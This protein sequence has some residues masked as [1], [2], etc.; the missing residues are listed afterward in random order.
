MV[1]NQ[2]WHQNGLCIEKLAM[3]WELWSKTFFLWNPSLF[4]NAAQILSFPRADQTGTEPLA[5]TACSLEWFNISVCLICLSNPWLGPL[6]LQE[7][8]SKLSKIHW[9]QRKVLRLFN[10]LWCCNVYPYVQL[11]ASSPY[12]LT[13]PHHIIHLYNEENHHWRCTTQS[14]HLNIGW[15]YYCF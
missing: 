12:T 5:A 6:S 8:C 4:R 1:S 9:L 7:S 3:D 15:I 11:L 14:V 13:P 10:M 2:F